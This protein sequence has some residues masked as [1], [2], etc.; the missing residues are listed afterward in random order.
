M[1]ASKDISDDIRALV[2]KA[3]ETETAVDMMKFREMIV[4][5]LGYAAFDNVMHVL[6]EEFP[7]GFAF[8]KD[9]PKSMCDHVARSLVSKGIPCTYFC[10]RV[11]SQYGF[12]FRTR[13][14]QDMVVVRMYANVSNVYR[15]QI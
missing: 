13:T 3:I 5:R 14:E 8:V 2:S 15:L 1:T 11:E 10:W 12:S 6:R 4:T 9:A 7:I